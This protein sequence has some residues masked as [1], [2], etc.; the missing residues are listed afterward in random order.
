V[1][2]LDRNYGFAHAVN[3]ALEHG[4]AHGADYF[5]LLNPDTSFDSDMPARLVAAIEANPRLGVISPKIYL[6]Q[7]PERLWGLGGILTR[8][9]LR[10]YGLEARDTGQFEG[11]RLDFVFGCAM[12]I[13]AEVLRQI[14]LMDE[15]FFMN[16]EEIDLCVRARAA[17]WQVGLAPQVRMRHA[18]GASTRARLY[19]RHFYLARSRMLFLRKHWT[20]F[21]PLPLALVELY[22]CGQLLRGSVRLRAPGIAAGFLRGAFAGLTIREATRSHAKDRAAKSGNRK[23]T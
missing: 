10:F 13:Q 12:L 3:D 9:G 19:L 1:I 16:F 15:R 14:G 4:L 23:S 18:G 8:A 7:P 5:L 22:N 2:A 20:R 11:R 21:R 6:E 17:G